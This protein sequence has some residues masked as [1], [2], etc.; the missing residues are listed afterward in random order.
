M[1]NPDYSELFA[2]YTRFQKFEK[3]HVV[4]KNSKTTVR[5]PLDSPFLK[6]ISGDWFDYRDYLAFINEDE[7]RTKMDAEKW[8]KNLQEH[9]ARIQRLNNVLNPGPYYA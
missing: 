5:I 9:S 1:E 6:R 2:N 7:V 3:G 4:F 8:H